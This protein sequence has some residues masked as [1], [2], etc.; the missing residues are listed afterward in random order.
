MGAFGYQPKRFGYTNFFDILDISVSYASF[1]LHVWPWEKAVDVPYPSIGY[2][3]ADFF[4]PDDWKPGYP[5]PAFENMTPRDGYWAAKIIVSFRDEHLWALIDAGTLSNPEA[6]QYLFETL[7]KRQEKIGRRYFAEVN[8]LDH[9][10]FQADEYGVT[11]SFT[12]LARE[13]G[14]AATSRSRYS[15]QYRGENIIVNRDL[16]ADTIVLGLAEL[17]ALRQA[18][19]GGKKAKDHQ[20]RVDIV[21]SRDGQPY[22]KPVRLWLWYDDVESTFQL[23]G[24]EHLD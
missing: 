16:D 2:F 10:E 14:F 19:N 3:E 11:I 13:H 4:E 5:L 12:D 9:F 6:R 18:F 21:T 7:K 22:S 15:L 23:V 8:P 20:F 24:I 1:G 17:A